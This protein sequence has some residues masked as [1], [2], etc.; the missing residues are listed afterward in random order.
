MGRE[1]VHALIGHLTDAFLFG[2]VSL[3]TESERKRN[4]NPRKIYHV[5]HGYL[6]AFFVAIAD[7]VSAER[8][9]SPLTAR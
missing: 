4:S 6:N 2:S 1:L 3:A 8:T 9:H 7:C 5:M